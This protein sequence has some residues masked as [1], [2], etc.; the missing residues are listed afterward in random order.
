MAA[1]APPPCPIL[2]LSDSIGAILASVIVASIFY[3]VANLQMFLYFAKHPKDRAFNKWLVF[4]LWCVNTMNQVLICVGVWQ[5]LV[6][7]YANYAFLQAF[8]IPLP[9]ATIVSLTRELTHLKATIAAI[10]QSYFV[11]RI[12]VFS[13]YKIIFPI[14]LVPAILAQPALGITYFV[15]SLRNPNLE[16]YARLNLV[17][18]A[19]NGTAAA[20][21]IAIT[22]CMA[23]LLVMGRTGFKKTDR[24]IIRLMFIS[25]NT[26][27][28]TALFAVIVVILSAAYPGKLVNTVTFFPLAS[29]YV[30]TLLANLNSRDYVMSPGSNEVQTIGSMPSTHPRFGHASQQPVIFISHAGRETFS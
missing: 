28:W 3:G 15:G 6:T 23:V 10:V 18:Y 14:I 20:V 22:A 24:M 29:L 7:N 17:T 4:G 19:A 11:H 1:A 9:L 27:A 30:N 2:D 21:D 5:Y 25:I 12:Y 8:H 26:G 16:E 13:K